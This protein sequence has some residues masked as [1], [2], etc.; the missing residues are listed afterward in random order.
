MIKT[1]SL[2]ALNILK[3]YFMLDETSPSGLTWIKSD[4]NRIKPGFVAGSKG[5]YWQVKFKGKDYGVHRLVYFLYHEQN[6]K[7]FDVEHKDGNKLN[8]EITNLRLATRQLNNANTRS[9]KNSSSK[10]KGV[11]WNKKLNKWSVCITKDYKQLYLG[12]FTCEEQ[13]ALTYNKHAKLLY[14]EYAL[15]NKVDGAS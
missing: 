3:E 5:R 11:S 7:D 2:P 1:N 10:Y 6:P 13:A 8:N 12:L 14:G 9:A 15:L 4:T